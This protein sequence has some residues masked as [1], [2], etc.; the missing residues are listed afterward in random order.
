VAV[1]FAKVGIGTQKFSRL[2][3]RESKKEL[4]MRFLDERRSLN[5]F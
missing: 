2:Q 5:D 4:K 3:K 1:P